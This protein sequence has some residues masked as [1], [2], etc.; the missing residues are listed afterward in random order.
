MTDVAMEAGTFRLADV[1]SKAFAI[2][3]RRFAP[4]ITLTIIASIPNFLV[5]FTIVPLMGGKDFA[6]SGASMGL[7]LADG[8]T[9]MLSTG[10]V[11]HGVVQELRGRAFSAA[12]SIRTVLRR[13]L[14]VLGLAICLILAVDL[15]MALLIIPGIIVNCVFAVSMPACIAERAGVFASMSRSRNL[16]KGH[17]WQTFGLVL[18]VMVGGY[19]LGMISS[20]VF[21]PIGQTGILISYAAVRVIISSFNGVL[22]SVCYYELRVAKEGVDIDKLASVFD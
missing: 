5:L 16:T 8:V 1:F 22:A 7:V 11:M 14:P 4:F 15:G 6:T 12:D 20:T 19:A 2:Y 9:Q 13:F 10:A 3:R 18:V 21:A 17:R